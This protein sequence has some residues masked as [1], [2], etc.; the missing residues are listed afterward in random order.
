VL[1]QF[2]ADDPDSP[3]CIT[4]V[5]FVSA[6]KALNG[7]YLGAKLKYDKH[8]AQVMGTWFS[9]YDEKPDR[10]LSFFFDGTFRYSYEPY[11]TDKNQPKAVVGEY[12]VSPGRMTFQIGRAKKTAK[13][14]LA[15]DTKSKRGGLT[16]QLDGELPEDL[17]QPFRSVP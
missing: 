9:G 16:L 13:M 3:V 11:D 7:S 12:D 8:I 1:D 2:P 10:F 14:A 17:K 5:I 4:D 6:G 15:S